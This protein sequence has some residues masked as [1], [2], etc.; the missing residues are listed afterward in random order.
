MER[1]EFPPAFFSPRICEFSV[2]K[3]GRLASSSYL[4]FW[5]FRVSDHRGTNAQSVLCS[6]KKEHTCGRNNLC[7]L[8]ITGWTQKILIRATIGWEWSPGWRLCDKVEW[9]AKSR[10]LFICIFGK[11]PEC[12]K[13]RMNVAVWER[14]RFPCGLGAGRGV[15]PWLMGQDV[16][17]N[18]RLVTLPDSL[19]VTGPKAPHKEASLRSIQ[20]ILMTS[21]NW[22]S[23]VVWQASNPPTHLWSCTRVKGAQNQASKSLSGLIVKSKRWLSSVIDGWG[24]VDVLAVAALPSALK[25]RNHSNDALTMTP[26]CGL[27]VPRSPWGRWGSGCGRCSWSQGCPW[28]PHS[29]HSSSSWFGTAGPGQ[30]ACLACSPY[31]HTLGEKTTGKSDVSTN[32][33]WG[34]KAPSHSSF[35]DFNFLALWEGHL[36]REG[37]VGLT[38]I[39]HTF[40]MDDGTH[41]DQHQNRCQSPCRSSDDASNTTLLLA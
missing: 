9:D 35:Q 21:H 13:M 17:V 23:N 6:Q 26:T 16:S 15:K 33:P 4:E 25:Y 11:L 36:E 1:P 8:A 10:L 19:A 27:G 18:R 30:I 39:W 7:S 5:L 28:R 29:S 34:V 12:R 32:L 40:W 37:W 22:T 38:C 14:V 41:Q 24:N 31:Q 3:K 20:I 2:I